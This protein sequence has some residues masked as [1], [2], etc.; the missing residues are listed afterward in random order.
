MT[1][2]IL[3]EIFAATKATLPTLID[4]AELFD[5]VYTFLGRFV[6]YPSKHAQVAHTLWVAHTHRMS[7]WDSTPRI[8]FLSPEPGSGKTRALEISETLVPRPIEAINATPAY[9]FRKV[10]DPEG[11]PTILFDEI[12]TLFGAKAKE[13]EE[14]RGI[15]NAGHRRGAM[16]GRCVVRGKVIE[17]EE[18]PA[19]CA[20]ALAGL[21]NLPDTIL[22]RSVVVRMRRRAPTEMV[23]PYRRRIHAE[24]GNRLRDLLGN[25]ASQ[26]SGIV[27]W[28]VMPAGIED[29]NAD[30]WESLRVVA[31]AAGG[32]WPERARVAAVALVADAKAG[33]PSLGIRL[34]SDLRKIFGSHDCMSTVS[35]LDALLKLDEAP[36]GDLRGKPIDS[37]HLAN[38][39]KPYCVTSK[40]VRIGDKTP[41]GYAQEDL[42]DPWT[43]YLP[44][45]GEP[46]IDAATSATSETPTEVKL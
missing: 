19:Y 46:A 9:I 27:V 31:D 34:L 30:V 44:K 6:S 3:D 23:E 17:T 7:V 15:L 32:D 4:S 16:A 28:P 11:A 37:R 36:W 40:G 43:R 24:E 1:T 20:V 22:T 8:A 2:Q 13:N 42:H 5:S 39:L 41:K 33:S 38:F 35:I 18:L 45:L 26:L 29:R 21:G 12:D 25:W 14:I 10:S